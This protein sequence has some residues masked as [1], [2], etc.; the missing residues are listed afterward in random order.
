[1]RKHYKKYGKKITATIL[2]VT[3]AL[4][5]A[6]CGEKTVDY[7]IDEETQG[8][9]STSD[10]GTLASKYGI[11]DECDTTLDVGDSGLGKIE[12]YDLDVTYPEGS[13][14][15]IATYILNELDD[16]KRQG[17]I[18]TLFDKDDGIYIYD[19]ENQTKEDIQED[20]DEYQ[21]MIEQ[22][23]AVGDNSEAE[24]YEEEIADLEEQLSSAPDEYPAAT[25]YSGTDYI[26]TMYGTEYYLYISESDSYIRKREDSYTYRNAES[27]EG[28]T[29]CYYQYD[30]DWLDVSPEDL[31]NMCELSE[32]EAQLIADDFLGMLGIDD[33]ILTDTDGLYWVYYSGYDGQAVLTELDGYSF[34]YTMAINNIPV[35]AK[36]IFNVD[37]INDD[38]SSAGVL[39]NEMT[40]CVD[41]N[42]IVMAN[43][44]DLLQAT[45]EVEENVS[46][47]TF[48]EMIEKANETVAAYYTDYPTNYTKVE[49]NDIELTYFL[50]ET[51]EDGVFKY[52]PAWVL[53]EYEIYTDY[54]EENYPSQMVVID[55]TDCSVID[56]LSL[57]KAL[58]QYYSY[59]DNDVLETTAASE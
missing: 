18:E 22:C 1:M 35:S 7:N 27:V 45:G 24:W 58:G 29:S 39:V 19:W 49:F 26:G 11:P 37:N 56:L 2:S 17:I 31:T 20:I 16:E 12:I 48:D 51:N 40:I 6:G 52:V 34:T 30:S 41:A 47:L 36:D 21:R 55:A 9:N 38:N 53:S 50:E 54:S 25:D 42:G 14:M 23:E 3:L 46:L 59:D 13:S 43:W 32:T 15:D 33:M 28:V 57:S 10:G 8:G 5:T 4:A 44:S